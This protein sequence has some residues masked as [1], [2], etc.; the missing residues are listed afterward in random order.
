MEALGWFLK[1]RLEVFQGVKAHSGTQDEDYAGI[2][3]WLVKGRRREPPVLRLPNH[4][5]PARVGMQGVDLCLSGA[6]GFNLQG[7]AGRQESSR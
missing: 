6:L 7:V 3:A 2:D 1:K 5:L 4:P